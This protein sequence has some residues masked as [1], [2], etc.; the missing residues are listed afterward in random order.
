MLMTA[1]SGQFAGAGAW[2]QLQQQQAQRAADQAEASA[3]SLQVQAR[4]AQVTAQRAQEN[5]RSLSVRSEQASQEASSARQG[6]AQSKSLAE[7]QGQ[8]ENLH[9]QV[10]SVLAGGDSAPA[11]T[12]SAQPVLNADGQTTGAV[13][14]VKA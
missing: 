6:L 13:I 2:A 5:A 11:A 10:K 1:I 8:L 12:P 9:Q 3:R 4:D 7:T 14:S